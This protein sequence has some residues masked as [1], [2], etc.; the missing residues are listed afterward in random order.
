MHEPVFLTMD[1][2]CAIHLDQIDRY[3]G[4]E[5]LRDHGA[6]AS[7]IAQPEASF[8]GA[9]L[10]PDL[11]AMAAAY[12]F[13]LVENHPFIDG[14]KRVGTVAALVFLDIN[15]LELRADPDALAE[16]VMEVAQG[17]VGKD[18]IATFLRDHSVTH[19]PDP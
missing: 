4:G 14:N 11:F 19:Q 15:G 13:H 9:Y 3:G 2:V 7:A 12:L 18:R 8:G 10:H 1:E 17:K 16:L 5:G 6:L